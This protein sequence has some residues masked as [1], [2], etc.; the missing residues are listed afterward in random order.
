MKL[1]KRFVLLNIYIPL[2]VFCSAQ[3]IPSIPTITP[4]DV[5]SYIGQ[6]VSVK[7]TVVRAYSAGKVYVLNF[8]Q[9][10]GGFEAVIPGNKYNDLMNS[11]IDINS[12][13]GKIVTVTGKIDKDPKYGIQMQLTDPATQLILPEAAAEAQYAQGIVSVNDA[14]KYVGQYATVQGKV[15]KVEPSKTGTTFFLR[16]TPQQNGFTVVIFPSV[17]A[18]FKKDKIDVKSFEGKT[19]QVNGNIKFYQEYGYEILLDKPES[20]KEVK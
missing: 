4:K 17:V 1:P 18:L 13:E 3:T 20:I 16:L 8:T 6:T 12:A 14:P 11:G 7:G 15:L 9:E 5:S 19:I 2:A 10:K